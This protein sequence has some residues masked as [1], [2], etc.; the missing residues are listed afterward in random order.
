MC[1]CC[2]DFAAEAAGADNVDGEHGCWSLDD[3]LWLMVFGLWLMVFGLW[4]L[5]FGGE[6]KAVSQ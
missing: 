2:C 6:L 4:S 5:V 1:E 3:G